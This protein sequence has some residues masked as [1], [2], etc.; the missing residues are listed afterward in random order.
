MADAAEEP[1]APAVEPLEPITTAQ[2]GRS[3][4]LLFSSSTVT[5]SRGADDVKV[6]LEGADSNPFAGLLN[7]LKTAL[8]RQREETDSADQK[9]EEKRQ[10][11]ENEVPAVIPTTNAAPTGFD[12]G[13]MLQ[14]ALGSFDEPQLSEIPA[15]V[16]GENG[17]HVDTSAPTPRT[18]PGPVR[19]YQKKMRFFQDPINLARTMGL[20]LLG[21]LVSD[22]V[23]LGNLSHS[24]VR[25]S[26]QLCLSLSKKMIF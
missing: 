5:N 19:K 16:D 2:S 13:A 4:P 23:F 11:T 3:L 25:S 12:I 6:E 18:A 24:K 20:P 14:N 8:K 22:P 7:T 9:P 10:K 17:N 26:G 1:Q 15:P 21:P